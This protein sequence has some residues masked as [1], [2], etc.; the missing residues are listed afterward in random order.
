M[1]SKHIHLCTLNWT[2]LYRPLHL[3]LIWTDWNCQCYWVCLFACLHVRPIVFACATAIFT[4]LNF[5]CFALYSQ[6]SIFLLSSLFEC[7]CFL[8]FLKLYFFGS[9]IFGLY[10]LHTLKQQERSQTILFMFN[11]ES[12]SM[13]FIEFHRIL[14]HTTIK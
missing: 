11:Y 4:P 1:F 3:R 6:F 14:V 12:I 10:R 5:D 9:Y 7:G 2:K 13:I 8:H